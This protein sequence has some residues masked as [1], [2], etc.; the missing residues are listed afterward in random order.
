MIFGHIGGVPVE[1]GL[2][3]VAPAAGAFAI[4][5]GARLRGLGEWLRRR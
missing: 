5:I 4:L 2:A 3:T 1:E